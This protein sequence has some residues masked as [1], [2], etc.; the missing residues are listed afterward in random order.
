DQH[1]VKPALPGV[2]NQARQLRPVGLGH[3]PAGIDVLRM[4]GPLSRS[5]VIAQVVQLQFTV[6][7]RGADST[8]ESDTHRVLAY[9]ISGRSSREIVARFP[10]DSMPLH[11]ASPFG[12]GSD[13]KGK[14][15]RFS[16]VCCRTATSVL[17]LYFFPQRSL[18]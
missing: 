1:G 18:C 6:L 13:D 14:G 9:M 3:A 10:P 11:R 12:G 2:L 7:V 17:Y 16:L 4:D 15:R 5:G 8:V